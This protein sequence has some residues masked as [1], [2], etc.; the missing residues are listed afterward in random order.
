MEP[1]SVNQAVAAARE[2]RRLVSGPG[3]LRET[4]AVF[5]E[6]FPGRSAVIVTDDRCLAAAGDA[7]R[8]RLEAEGIDSLPPVVLESAGLPAESGQVARLTSL[9][10]GHSAIPVAVGSGTINDLTKLAAHRAGRPYLCVATAASMDGYTAFG[11]SITHEGSKET[12]DCPAP[13]AVIADIDVIRRAPDNMNAWG[14]ADLCAKVTAGADWLLADFL[15][16]EPVDSTAWRI[17]QSG[18]L[19]ALDD[20]HG[21]RSGSGETV[22]R[23]VDGLM[24]SGFAMQVNRTSRPASG[25]EHQFSHLWDMEHHTHEGRSPSHGSK[26][27]IATLAVTAFY[28]V[29]LDLPMETLDPDR[30]VARWPAEDEWRRLAGR[31]SSDP[32]VA[33]VAER[34]IAA[35]QV[36]PDHLRKQLVTLAKGWVSLKRRLQKQLLPFDRLKGMMA[37]AGAPVE[38]EAIGISRDRLRRTFRQAF[39]IRRRFTVLDLAVRA[40]V[41]DTCL[42]MLFGPSGRWPLTHTSQASR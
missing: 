39:F 15:G 7:V 13:A 31:V 14:Y 3:A 22:Q 24:L 42:E 12:F 26:V 29:L 4:P 2:T 5:R 41:L 18:L 28:E 36:S 30:I 8:R 1:V 35:K 9:L 27:G 23:L 10:D 11:A 32:A 16:E 20:P 37:A 19:S 25:A 33:A 17:V 21:I 34:E 6:T 38:P 40:G